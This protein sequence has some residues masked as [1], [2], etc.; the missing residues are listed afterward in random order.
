M[1]YNPYMLNQSYRQPASTGI[2]WV[3][4]LAGANAFQLMPNTNAILLDS[5][6]ENTMY[7]KVADSV[8]MCTLRTFQYTEV[9]DCAPDYVTKSE[10][11]KMLDEIREEIRREQS[12][13]A[14]RRWTE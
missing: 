6:R 3:Q 11:Q 10:M 5:E 1:N 4:G 8:G 12:L 2:N 7:L 14:P 9:T 13:P